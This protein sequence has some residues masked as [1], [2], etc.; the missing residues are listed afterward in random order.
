[1]VKHDNKWGTVCDDSFNATDAEAACRTLGFDG[2][3]YS[4]TNTGFFESKI[5]ILMDDVNCANNS[6]NFLECSHRGWGTEN[7][8]HSEDVLL[9]CNSCKH[10]SIQVFSNCEDC[11]LCGQSD[12]AYSSTTSWP[13]DPIRNVFKTN[14]FPIVEENLIV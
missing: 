6:T 7:C 2:N 10:Q 8:G 4:N 14:F 13:G 11:T 5:P 3:S 1:M 12:S 9:D